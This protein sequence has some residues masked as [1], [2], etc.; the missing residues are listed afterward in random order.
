MRHGDDVKLQALYNV[1]DVNYYIRA[2][3]LV[4]T[5]IDNIVIV[6]DDISRCKE[7]LESRLPHRLVYS[8]FQDNLQ[9]FV[10]LH[11]ARTLV[12]ANSSFSW[13]AAFLKHIHRRSA[14]KHEEVRVFAPAVWYNQSGAFAH[15]NSDA[16]FLTSG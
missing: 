15:L 4:K 14:F 1:L 7:H 16:S 9:D 10:L 13:W 6:S 2:L 11:L 3:D 8:P 5:R 12:I